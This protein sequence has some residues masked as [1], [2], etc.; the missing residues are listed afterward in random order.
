MNFKKTTTILAGS[1]KQQLIERP[2]LQYSVGMQVAWRFSCEVQL[3]HFTTVLQ[4][5]EGFCLP[6]KM[7]QCTGTESQFKIAFKSCS[8]VTIEM[9]CFHTDYVTVKASLFKSSS[10]KAIFYADISFDFNTGKVTSQR[11]AFLT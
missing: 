9:Y 4:R 11:Y 3:Y 1:L 6:L 10:K 7:F 5:L 8:R 2:E